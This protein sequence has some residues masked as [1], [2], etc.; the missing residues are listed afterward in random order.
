LKVEGSLSLN[1]LAL[2]CAGGVLVLLGLPHPRPQ[3]LRL[4]RKPQPLR[5]SQLLHGS[6]V[7]SGGGSSGR[8][9]VLQLSRLPVKACGGEQKKEEK[10][11][12]KKDKRRVLSGEESQRCFEQSDHQD[13]FS[14]FFSFSFTFIFFNC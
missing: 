9:A 5:A 12:E 4:G 8:G 3:A 10:E 6:G 11:E 14:S 7:R 2:G 1:R 13:G